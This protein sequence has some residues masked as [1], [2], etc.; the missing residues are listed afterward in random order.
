S[1][2]VGVQ[3]LA[4]LDVAG[5]PGIAGGDVRVKL[6]ESRLPAGLPIRAGLLDAGV[7]AVQARVG[8]DLEVLAAVRLA[9]PEVVLRRLLALGGVDRH[10]GRAAGACADPEVPPAL[11]ERRAEL[12]AGAVTALDGHHLGR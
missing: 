2:R 8:G 11:L 5:L 7:V 4:V 12:L 3:L 6:I 1:S 9:G 10:V